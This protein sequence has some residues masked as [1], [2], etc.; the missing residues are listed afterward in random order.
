MV[1]LFVLVVQFRIVHPAAVVMSETELV[2]PFC[3]LYIEYRVQ[4]IQSKE[5]TTESVAPIDVLLRATSKLH[6]PSK[7]G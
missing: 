2:D 1:W 4:M 3:E 6:A 5:L 7:H